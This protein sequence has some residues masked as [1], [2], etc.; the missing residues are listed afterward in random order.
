M[1]NTLDTILSRLEIC[2]WGYEILQLIKTPKG[3]FYVL[4]DGND[5]MFRSPNIDEILNRPM[6]DK[7]KSRVLA[8]FS[9][10]AEKYT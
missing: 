6:E 10:P 8:Y 2:A 5:E 1:N 9:L 3:N 4:L 7:M